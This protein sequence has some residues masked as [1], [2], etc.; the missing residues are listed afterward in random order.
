MP[1]KRTKEL[2][3]FDLD[4]TLTNSLKCWGEATLAAVRL[5][6]DE[7]GLDEEKTIEAIRRAPSQYRFS[8]FGSLTEWLDREGVLP[9]P[10]DPYDQYRKDIT[11]HYL[12][13]IWFQRQKEMT[14]FYDGTVTA[15]TAIK[16]Q[17]TATAIYTD[18][19][20]S[21]LIRRTWLLARNARKQGQ[22]SDEHDLLDLFDHYYCQP[23]I[24]QDFD[25]L[26]DVDL[27][28]VHR[29]KRNMTLWQDLVYKPS[30]DH[31]L[32]IL[33]DFGVPAKRALMVGD[34]AKD[35]GSARPLAMDFAWCRFGAEIDPVT[36]ATAQKIASP[37]FQYGLAS[38]VACFNQHSDPTHTLA[39]DIGELMTHFKFIKGPAFSLQAHN[40]R[41]SPAYRHSDAD[42]ATDTRV[43]KR[44]AH[45]FHAQQRLPPLGPPTHLEPSAPVSHSIDPAGKAGPETP[46]P[47]G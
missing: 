17:G 37:K 4:N 39:C 29:M 16:A 12:R 26:K 41:S 34:T 42:P 7:F 14:F 6:V 3:I 11:K 35:G 44:M 24:E 9:R 5:M 1:R 46:K 45:D 8:D 43:A 19:E 22:I 25:I 32:I 47:Q 31:G 33:K 18:T 21:S 27:P 40:G 36:V 30:I 23:S 2:V 10:Q 28:F 20:A 13:Q 38:I 15:L